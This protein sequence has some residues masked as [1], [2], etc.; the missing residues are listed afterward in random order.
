MHAF[1]DSDWG[2]D[3]DSGRST[4]GCW[5]SFGGPV[6][7][8]SR[9]QRTPAISSA[10]AEYM[11]AGDVTQT[12]LFCRA[13]LTEL[14]FAPQGPTQILTDSKSAIAIAADPVAHK[15]T[16]HINIRYHFIRQHCICRRIDLRWIPGTKNIADLLTKPVSVKTF[17]SMIRPFL[18]Y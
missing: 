12:V 6:Y 13:L 9:L 10:E 5:V 16:K 1:S 4:T 14:G 17:F 15:R 11:A 7:W 18:G 8:F 3:R 2:G